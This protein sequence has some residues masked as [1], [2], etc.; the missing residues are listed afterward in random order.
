M[1]LG[2]DCRHG[3]HHYNAPHAV[4]YDRKR[5]MR[6]CRRCSEMIISWY[7]EAEGKIVEK[8]QR[9]SDITSNQDVVDK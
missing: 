6:T 4:N 5:W 8:I 7:D 1:P 3:F 2:V 9:R